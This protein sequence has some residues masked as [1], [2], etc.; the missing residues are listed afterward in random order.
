[1]A[2]ILGSGKTALAAEHFKPSPWVKTHPY[3]QQAS[4]KLGFGILNL[5]SGWLSLFYEPTRGNFFAGCARGIWRTVAYMAG[6][7]IHAVTFP[8]PIDLPL[9]EGGIQFRS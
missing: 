4:H 9:P 3:F 5:S 7:A 2:L 6:G 8:I 1:M